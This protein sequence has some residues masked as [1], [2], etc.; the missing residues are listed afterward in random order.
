MK[1]TKL[2]LV[3]CAL[4][5]AITCNAGP[6]TGWVSTFDPQNNNPRFVPGTEA[7][8]SP[9][10]THADQDCIMANFPSV[11]R[12]WRS[13][14]CPRSASISLRA[15]ANSPRASARVSPRMVARSPS[16]AVKRAAS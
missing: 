12:L 2:P 3:G 5:A 8:D 11:D 13:T 16:M 6:V 7:T 1:S 4:A 9:V 10:T 14:I 15:A